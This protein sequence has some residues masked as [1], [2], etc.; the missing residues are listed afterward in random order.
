LAGEI[1]LLGS[2]IFWSADETV[3][4][5]AKTGGRDASVRAAVSPIMAIETGDL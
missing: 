1:F 3:A 5:H 2:N 4:I